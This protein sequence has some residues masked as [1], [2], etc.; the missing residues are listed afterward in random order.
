MLRF[1]EPILELTARHVVYPLADAKNG[2]GRLRELRALRRSQWATREELDRMRTQR[3]RSMLDHARATVPF[4]ESHWAGAD[5][6]QSIEALEQLPVVRKAHIRAAGDALLSSAFERSA[7]LTAKTG[8]S[9]GTSLSLRFDFDCQQRRNGAAF[10]S[11]E[12]A[13]W[14]VGASIGALWGNPPKAVGFRAQLR[15]AVHE[16]I[17]YCDTMLLDDRVVREFVSELRGSGTEFLFGHAHS[18]FRFSE[19]VER[20][21]LE[22]PSLRGIVSTSMMLLRPERELIER[23]LRCR[24]TDRYGCEEVGLIASECERHEGHH[25][26]EEHVI[27]ELV[28]E[29][30]RRVPDGEPG[31]VCVTDL[32]NRGMP[33]I[34]YVVEDVA[35]AEPSPCACGRVHR[36][37]R[38]IVGRTADFLKRRGGGLVAG[39]SLVERTLTLIP[40]LAQLQL[41]QERLCEVTANVV[42]DDRYSEASA[43]AL[44]AELQRSLGAD[45]TVSVVV[46]DSLVQ[47][48]NGKYRFSICRC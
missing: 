16:R 45:V 13:G 3:L 27:V 17:H 2:S 44:R 43:D 12:W 46:R 41:V 11:D 28:D 6:P 37:L 10:R 24:V 40:G 25:V 5:T 1:V 23:V 33:L 32:V 34:R 8:G 18:I 31:L 9:T 22:P 42:P 47:E 38:Q 36:R 15:A 35:I 7:L 48:A 39:V 21:G 4:Y 29:S 19:S 14:R 20:Q 30:G 26:N